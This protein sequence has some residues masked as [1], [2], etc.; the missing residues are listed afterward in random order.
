MRISQ[1]S[2]FSVY[3][4]P[5]I[6]WPSFILKFHYFNKSVAQWGPLTEAKRVNDHQGIKEMHFIRHVNRRL[7][8]ELSFSSTEYF[9]DIFLTKRI[10]QKQFWKT[11]WTFIR[12]Q[13]MRGFE[14]LS[15]MRRIDYFQSHTPWTNMKPQLIKNSITNPIEK[16]A[17]NC[18]AFQLCYLIKWTQST[19]WW[20]L[21]A[22]RFVLYA[23]TCQ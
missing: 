5:R 15:P 7:I 20:T 12:K 21:C 22:D 11:K 9:I 10:N 13:L 17:K 23:D 1:V 6:F 4:L 8:F 2:L 16:H 19:V 3:P 18:N 14:S